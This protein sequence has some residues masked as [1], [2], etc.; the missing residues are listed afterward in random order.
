MVIVNPEIRV[1]NFRHYPKA[2]TKSDDYVIMGSDLAS[3]ILYSPLYHQAAFSDRRS[4][5]LMGLHPVIDLP[6]QQETPIHKHSLN[7]PTTSTFHPSTNAYYSTLH[8][9]PTTDSPP[10]SI[11]SYSSTNL[12]NN[13]Y[14]GV[15]KLSNRLDTAFM[16]RKRSMREC[17]AEIEAHNNT[18]N[19][20][21]HQR[22]KLQ[23][24]KLSPA[25]YRIPTK[26]VCDKKSVSSRRIDLISDSMIPKN[27]SKS[28]FKNMS[29][30]QVIN[31]PTSELSTS[32]TYPGHHHDDGASLSDS[33]ED[34][35]AA[36]MDILGR[37]DENH[38]VLKR[39]QHPGP[40]LDDKSTI[41]SWNG[42]N[43]EKKQFEPSL[44]HKRDDS[45]VVSHDRKKLK[46]N[47]DLLKKEGIKI[48]KIGDD[49]DNE[50]NIKNEFGI[51]GWILTIL[52]YLIIFITIPISAFMCIKVVQEYERA[53]IF[54]LG[55][56]LPG[57]ARGPGIFFI[58]PCID[59]Y[60]KVDLRVLSFEVPPQ[61]I[62]SKDSVTVAVD[63]VVY[64][65]ISNATI[66]VTN[67]EDCSRSTKL[68]AQTTLRNILGTRTLAE[69]LSDRESI[70][71]TMQNLLDQATECWGVKVER[72]EVKDVRLPV[73]LQRAM[74]KEAESTRE[75]RAKV[76]A[77]EGEKKAS[78]AL[79]EAA[80]VLSE[81]P[82]SIQLRYLQTLNNIAAEKNSTIVFPIPLEIFQMFM[83]KPPPKVEL[84]PPP[85]KKIRSCCV[86]KYP[87]WVQ[88]AVAPGNITS[89]NQATTTL[90]YNA[91]G[92]TSNMSKSI[93]Y[94][95][96]FRANIGVTEMP[97]GP[98]F[99]SSEHRATRTS[100]Y[101]GNTKDPK[102][103]PKNTANLTTPS[104]S[105]AP[106]KTP[107]G[108]VLLKKALAN[109]MIPVANSENKQ[110]LCKQ[111]S[112][113]KQPDNRRKVSNDMSSSILM[114]PAWY[115]DEGGATGVKN[116]EW[117]TLP[118][119][120]KNPIK[121]RTPT[122][123]LNQDINLT[124]NDERTAI[125]YQNDAN[126]IYG[127]HTNNQT[128]PHK[129]T[130]KSVVSSIRPTSSSDTSPTS[131]TPKKTN[132]HQDNSHLKLDTPKNY[133]RSSIN[134]DQSKVSNLSR[135][136]VTFSD[137]IIIN[138]IA[139]RLDGEGLEQFLAELEGK[140]KHEGVEDDEDVLPSTT[141]AVTVIQNPLSNERKCSNQS[142]DSNRLSGTL[143]K[144]FYYNEQD[145]PNARLLDDEEDC[146]FD[147]VT[148]NLPESVKKII[149]A[150]A[151]A[152]KKEPASYERNLTMGWNDGSMAKL[153]V[154]ESS[155]PNELVCDVGEPSAASR[156][157]TE[158]GEKEFF[159][160]GG[161]HYNGGMHSSSGSSGM[162]S[163]SHNKGVDS[164]SSNSSGKNVKVDE[165]SI[166]SSKMKS[167]IE[168][169]ESQPS[170]H[171]NLEKVGRS[172]HLMNTIRDSSNDKH[173]VVS[174]SSS[175]EHE[176]HRRLSTIPGSKSP[177]HTSRHS[178]FN[179]SPVKVANINALKPPRGNNSA[180]P[181]RSPTTPTRY[182]DVQHEGIKIKPVIRSASGYFEP[183]SPN[184]QIIHIIEVPSKQKREPKL[185]TP[186]QTGQESIQASFYDNVSYG[187]V[188]SNEESDLL[189]KD[190][191]VDKRIKN[192][193]D[194][195]VKEDDPLKGTLKRENSFS[196]RPVQINIEKV[197]EKRKSRGDDLEAAYQNKFLNVYGNKKAPIVKAESE[198]IAPKDPEHIANYGLG[199]DAAYNRKNSMTSMTS[200]SS[201]ESENESV[202]SAASYRAEVKVRRNFNY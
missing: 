32:L 84:P 50:T 86:H 133:R 169:L 180:S 171:L 28:D 35:E 200:N 178:S 110:E 115:R 59:S 31:R 202:V 107:E 183:P 44:P 147:T 78:R 83:P 92:G 118:N 173:Y 103:A 145:H 21:P 22:P 198:E 63:A 151:I 172:S 82:C 11:Y 160:V 38:D 9:Q 152:R 46:E 47:G 189:K 14:V 138:E 7:Q 129:Q 148:L 159:S 187:G 33:S 67:V 184:K 136:S 196:S 96:G 131:V 48:L 89:P 121:Q 1:E 113:L 117:E 45:S 146:E 142:D 72:V 8:L 88:N 76:I 128:S 5:S 12:I 64:F 43:P 162:D 41:S 150:D 167:A 58:I 197:S 27:S 2:H 55:R 42:S 112:N 157:S 91:G 181:S 120:Q 105:S 79:K 199:P 57:G 61:E 116:K 144:S 52:S 37:V 143:D 80:E 141:S 194:T 85:T 13:N 106:Q 94:N 125:D 53:V 101:L 156:L 68:L 102:N 191:I 104:K 149:K 34:L 132:E 66:S 3:K 93:T 10:S 24:R 158:I 30:S 4:V 201:R 109:R 16:S 177:S 111:S 19:T 137:Q 51:C 193:R 87:D 139:R 135:K 130:K 81:N 29:A 60:R 182:D 15:R 123:S 49:G 119:Q 127:Q 175:E 39:H 188:F 108:N 100:G 62:L 190:D 195:L 179:S 99:P 54:R 161:S 71:T 77:A 185:L 73:S 126:S 98:T 134:S 65:R 170:D 25:V 163:Q 166:A 176:Y 6:Q 186:K 17:L 75:S 164:G 155:D 23:M 70:S 140:D 69:M 74:A 18:N 40:G 97:L 124:L 36:A 114:S 122:T 154:D 153:L 168:S 20:D 56:L 26:L 192:Y 90:Q 165:I 95:Q 174:P